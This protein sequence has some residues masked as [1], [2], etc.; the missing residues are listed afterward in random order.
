MTCTLCP[1]EATVSFSILPE[2]VMCDQCADEN[3]VRNA[4]TPIDE[5]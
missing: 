4:Y 3:A 2:D 1:R 5:D